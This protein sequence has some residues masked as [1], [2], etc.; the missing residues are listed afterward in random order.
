MAGDETSDT[1]LAT[2]PLLFSNLI[3][4]AAVYITAGTNLMIDVYNWLREQRIHY[5]VAM[6]WDK[7]PPAV[8][9]WNR[10]HPSMRTS[11]SAGGALFLV[12]STSAG[13]ETSTRQPCG[14]IPIDDRGTKVHRA[15]KPVALYERAMI[16]SSAPGEIVVDCFAGSGSCIIAAEKHQRKA[17]LM[18]MEPRYCDLIVARWMT[19]HRPESHGQLEPQNMRI[20]GTFSNWL[21]KRAATWPPS[22]SAGI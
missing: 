6:V 1:A 16:N 18:E 3:P 8:I 4:Q 13:S 5:G 17:Y 10:Y 20:Y 21:R 15:Q 14:D 7:G 2:L 9:S 19:S 11:S 12:A 22:A